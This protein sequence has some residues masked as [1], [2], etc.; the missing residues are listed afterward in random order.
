LLPSSG[1]FARAL[2]FGVGA[3]A[4]G[5]VGALGVAFHEPIRQSIEDTIPQTKPMFEFVL[6]PQKSR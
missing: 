3:I 6:G 5:G 4:V 1:G 2:K